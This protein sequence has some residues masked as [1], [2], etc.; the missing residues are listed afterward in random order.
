MKKRLAFTMIELVMVIV[1]LGILAAVAIPKLDND[2]RVGARDNIYS[3]LQQTRQLALVDNKTNPSNANWQQE[4]WAIRFSS[5]G[6][7]GF[8]YS[9]FSNIDHD[10]NIDKNEVTID[11]SNGKYIYHVAGSNAI[12]DDESPN[13][14]LG[15]KFGINKVD[16]TGGCDGGETQVYDHL[17]QPYAFGKTIAF[18]HL[19]R[20]YV[21]GIFSS[22]NL[23]NGIMT[24]DCII[25]VGFTDT[26]LEDIVFTI[27]KET[28]FV[29]IL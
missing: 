11:P 2:I 1:V 6:D 18:D 19:G 3:A 12:Q 22:I 7:D 26:D 17:G 20:P 13:V 16:F 9:L 15:T 24:T 23:Y 10:K 29:D 8:T 21:S 14:F 25:T 4:L 5:D 27:S 28:G